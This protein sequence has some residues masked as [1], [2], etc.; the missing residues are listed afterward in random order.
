MTVA[1][2][3]DTCEEERDA[4]EGATGPADLR[5]AT[6][7]MIESLRNVVPPRRLAEFHAERISAAERFHAA[8][9]GLGLDD[10]SV[11]A[12]LDAALAA[13]TAL[14]TAAAG[15]PERLHA[16]L[17]DAGCV[18]DPELGLLDPGQTE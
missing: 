15:L 2:Y 5:P 11:E 9:E 14:D 16:R 6:A 18:N 4:A 7:A 3:L 1:E 10:R 8:L 17:V 13:Q 12:F